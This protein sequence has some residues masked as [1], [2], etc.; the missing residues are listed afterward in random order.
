MST[1]ANDI[2]G[3]GSGLQL[4]KH[5]NLPT[6]STSRQDFQLESKSLKTSKIDN[7]TMHLFC[8]HDFSLKM[9][10][11]ILCKRCGVGKTA[12][13]LGL[14]SS[15]LASK[16]HTNSISHDNLPDTSK[17]FPEISNAAYLNNRADYIF[18]MHQVR[19]ALQIDQ[20]AFH[21]GCQIL[22]ML[23]TTDKASE[24]TS[25]ITK[26]NFNS[27]ILP[28]NCLSLATK[29]KEIKKFVPKNPRV[30][31]ASYK[32]LRKDYEKDSRNFEND[33]MIMNELEFE[34]GQ[35]IDWNL[36][37]QTYYDLVVGYLSKGILTFEDEI[38]TGW[39]NFYDQKVKCDSLSETMEASLSLSFVNALPA[40]R[41]KEKEFKKV[42]DIEAHE[43]NHL[44]IVYEA[45]C[46]ELCYKLQFQ[47]RF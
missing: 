25:L 42:R 24:I 13:S 28:L 27:F 10:G 15:L 21:L 37:E 4:S 43:L 23:F 38:S 1:Q 35:A 20:Q 33:M 26:K 46:L 9:Q 3:C 2:S 30:L 22:D 5:A 16:H 31:M 40:I 41:R 45:F 7:E 18:H 44:C 17:V 47:F 11:G 29:S 8:D 36:H 12:S 19:L 39:L 14:K 6:G 34:I 32:I